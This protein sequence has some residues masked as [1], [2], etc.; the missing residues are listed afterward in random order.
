M[1]P[2]LS[3]ARRRQD[4]AM[5]VIDD[6]DLL[7]LWARFGKPV[8][9]GSVRHGLVVEPDIDIEV[10]SDN[11]R[12]DEGLSVMAQVVTSPNVVA[13]IFRN[14]HDTRG[15]WLYWEV[16]YRDDDEKTWTIETFH[17]GPGDPYAHFSERLAEGMKRI[18]TEK[19]R[20]A[21]L[22]IKES[23]CDRGVMRKYRSF[24]I[25][26][27]VMEAGVDSLNE[28]LGWIETG[29]AVGISD[30]VPGGADGLR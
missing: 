6:L 25:Y 20:L 10:Y 2:L 11:P 1:N 8:V 3:R 15:K 18:M 4:R 23:L 13:V 14:D 9:V 16:Q 28:F 5:Q 17:C 22:G 12:I 27:A 24:D 29:K 7:H 19:H 26:R 21:I 30:W